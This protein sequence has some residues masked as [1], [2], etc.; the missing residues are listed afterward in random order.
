MTTVV[1]TI[2]GGNRVPRLPS[3]EATNESRGYVA[4]WAQAL[5]SIFCV[6]DNDEVY[7]EAFED[8][9][10]V[11]ASGEIGGI[12]VKDKAGSFSI[13]QEE[14]CVML[15]RW[16]ALVEG[17]P[18]SWF[19]FASTQTAGNLHD[20]S[21]SFRRWVSGDQTKAVLDELRQSVQKF[22]SGRHADKFPHLERLSENPGDF[23]AYWNCITWRLG[24]VGLDALIVRLLERIRQQYS[25]DS[26]GRAKER[27]YGWIGALALSA[28]SEDI[29]D[30]RW[31]R[32][33]L[34]GIDP[35]T[36]KRFAFLANQL[37]RLIGDAAKKHAATLA[38]ILER[39]R[40]MSG[41][42]G[43]AD[44]S[45]LRSAAA[46]DAK[47]VIQTKSRQLKPVGIL[48]AIIPLGV[49]VRV[50]S[51]VDRYDSQGRLSEYGDQ[52]IFLPLYEAC[53]RS[54]RTVLLAD[55]GSG[56]STLAAQFVLDTID[57]NP[58]VLAFFIPAKALRLPDPFRLDEL[59]AACGAYLTGQIAPQAEQADLDSLL[60]SQVEI[61][62][63]VDG[64]DEVPRPRAASLF[65]QLAALVDCWPN[66]QV[67]ATGRPVE[68]AGVTYETWGLSRLDRLSDADKRAIFQAEAVAEGYSG[69][70][71]AESTKRRSSFLKRYPVLDELASTPLA[72]RLL[73][74]KL[75]DGTL[76]VADS[77]GD[78]LYGL[79]IERLGQW[80]E[81]DHKGTPLERFES[82]F[83]TA[84]DRA[85]VLGTLALVVTG[86][87]VSRE[88]AEE[89][90][91]ERVGGD[92]Q[93]AKQALAFFQQAGLISLDE[94]VGFNFQPLLEISAG[95]ALLGRWQAGLTPHSLG[96]SLPWRVA[97][98]AAAVSHRRGLLDRVRSRLQSITDDLLKSSAGVP[99]ACMI[100]SESRDPELACAIIDAFRRLGRKPLYWNKEERFTSSRAIAHTVHLA[101][102]KGFNWFVAD[103]LDARYPIVHR[104][105]MVIDEV[106][107]HWTWF[108]FRTI[109]EDQRRKLR[110]LVAPLLVGGGIFSHVLP[111]LAI[112]VPDAFQERQLFWF[113]SAFLD[114]ELLGAEAER[115]LT[116]FNGPSNRAVL[117]DI[118][119]RRAPNSRKGLALF[120]KLFA[121]ERPPV[122]I[123]QG[124]LRWRALDPE[125][126]ALAE[127]LATCITLAEE[128]R[129]PQ[130]L[131]WCLSDQESSVSAGAA[132]LLYERGETRLNIAGNAL[133]N[134]LHDGG[135][136]RRAEQILSDLIGQRGEKGVRWLAWHMAARRGHNGGHSGYWRVLLK[137]LDPAGEHSPDILA[138]C[139]VAVGP[140]L[141]SRYPEVRDGLQQLL[142]GSRGEDF[143]R[144]L[145]AGLTDPDPEV[146]H[147]C[148]S[149]LITCD[150]RGEA[151]ALFV[152]VA[153]RTGITMMS[154]E[155][156]PFCL[157]LAF[158]H[159]VLESL[160]GRLSRMGHEARAYALAVLRRH[161]FPPSPPRT[162]GIVRPPAGGR[163]LDPGCR[164]RR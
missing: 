30:R 148:G 136:V 76:P 154:H 94:E 27:L 21:D 106:L 161:R 70:D 44:L 123:A 116:R 69:M 152:V 112:L 107:R 29:A 57:K 41:V 68:L 62:L 8:V 122:P 11:A 17:R 22:V 33:K 59:V 39:V 42:S 20:R 140:Y 53:R 126:Q 158:G 118:F 121:G 32:K 45:Q 159:D 151:E 80:S 153:T 4:G 85:D 144:A 111:S 93:V 40:S 115:L 155:W 15:E 3:R 61:C 48:P 2:A 55:L 156:E 1:P 163:E 128:E 82:T 58:H 139:A 31:T 28:S 120:F 109:T 38:E 52:F 105:S 88:E 66:A 147:G 160:H 101:G 119:C 63:V 89:V 14:S 49:S 73:Y 138:G 157:S 145:R 135:Y 12:Q 114:D 96:Q 130:F 83:A 98:F 24:G 141:L 127:A 164:R 143:R 7:V 5:D 72:V 81:R 142:T 134:A 75:D 137:H 9:V 131:R 67:L 10:V 35:Q 65:R 113:V 100:A 162:G 102:D 36:D 56:K 74:S 13:T 50:T 133:L 46:Q 150:P 86:K 47:T 132:I 87:R 43:S 19:R 79:L 95:I 110:P 34:F 78:L 64:L 54:R 23:E 16:A 103:Y 90:L 84:E 104:G 108:A 18:R 97:A 71:A 77:I 51:Q 26:E 92:Y 124:L 37:E 25:G 129:W 6:G 91:H 125:N 117:I 60:R 146:R 99:A 149:I